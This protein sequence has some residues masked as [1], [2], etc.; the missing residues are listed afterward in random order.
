MSPASPCCLR[1][2]RRRP[3]R[4]TSL[5]VWRPF[6]VCRGRRPAELFFRNALDNCERLMR[7]PSRAVAPVCH[8]F[9]EQ[10]RG[11]AQSRFTLHRGRTGGHA[12]FQRLDTAVG[13]IAAPEANRIFPHA[14]RLGDLWAGPTRQRQQH[15]ARPVGFS[16]ISGAGQSHQGAAL[17]VACRNRRLSRHATHLRIGADSESQNLSVGQPSGICL[18]PISGPFVA[19]ESFWSRLPA[20]VRPCG[21]AAELIG[22]RVKLFGLGRIGITRWPRESRRRGRP[23]RGR[24]RHAPGGRRSRDGEG[25]SARLVRYGATTP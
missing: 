13:E 20:A 5:A 19:T 7:T 4:S 21:S 11:H 8:R 6:S 24:F 9:L 1:S 16:T 25:R 3:T 23:R 18:A 14:E 22:R 2:C 17:F 15:G 12:R 10:G